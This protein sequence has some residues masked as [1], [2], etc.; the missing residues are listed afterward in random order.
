[1]ILKNGRQLSGLENQA[2]SALG[3]ARKSH[4]RVKTTSIP[5]ESDSF[6]ERLS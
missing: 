4:A 1:M 2:N 3:S 6:L 5:S